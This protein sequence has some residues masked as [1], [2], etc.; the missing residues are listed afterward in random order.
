MGSDYKGNKPNRLG[1]KY[2]VNGIVYAFRSEMNM[3]VHFVVLFIV[4]FCGYALGVSATEWMLLTLT[5]GAV[6]ICELFNTAMEHLLDYLAP[7]IHPTVG[8][9]KDLT[10]GAVLVAAFT[11]IIIGL[12]IFLPKFLLIL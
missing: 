12:I 10:A 8:K 3:K 6:L 1:V 4:L 11:S 9:I 7:E 2:A 5:I